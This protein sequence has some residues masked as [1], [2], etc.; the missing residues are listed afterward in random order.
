MFKNMKQD[1]ETIDILLNSYESRWS[2]LACSYDWLEYQLRV[3]MDQCRCVH[4]NTDTETPTL[5]TL[6]ARIH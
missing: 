1:T 2:S 3:G 5:I 4:R 6:T